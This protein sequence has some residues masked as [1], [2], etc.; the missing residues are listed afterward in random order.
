MRTLAYTVIVWTVV[1][2]S[3]GFAEPRPQA[4]GGGTGCQPGWRP[5]E[6]LPTSVGG[7][8]DVAV[9]DDGGG[10]GP[11]LFVS[12][13]AWDGERWS[14]IGDIPGAIHA[15]ATFDGGGGPALYFGGEFAE[16]DGLPA[17]RIARWDGTSLGPV[18]TGMYAAVQAF[19]LFDDGAGAALYAGGSFTLAGGVAANRVAKFDGTSW[20]PLGSG[21]NNVVRALAVYDDGSGPALYAGGGFTSAGGAGAS[22]VAKWDGTGWAPLSVGVDKTILCLEVFDDGNGPALY[23]G[24]NLTQAG[25]LAASCV[26]RWNGAWSS[27]GAGVAGQVT[28]FAVFD[29]GSGPRLVATI[30]NARLELWDGSAWSPPPPVGV[31]GS[32]YAFQVFD[33]GAGPELYIGGSFTRAGEATS[34]GIARWDGTGWASLAGGIAAGIVKGFAIFDD[35]AGSALFA[36]GSFEEIGGV[37]ADGLAKWNGTSWSA[38]GGMPDGYVNAVQTFD[39]GS[40]SALF[41]GGAFYPSGGLLRGVVKLDG[42]SW[43]VPGLGM[44]SGV[45]ALTVFDD[46]TG[47]ALYAGDADFPSRVARWDGTSWSAVGSGST[48]ERVLCLVGF[49]DGSGPA[50]YAGGWFTTMGGTPASRVAR[51]DGVSWSPLGPGLSGMNDRVRAL[52]VFDDGTGPA[53]YAAGDFTQAGAVSSPGIARWDGVGWASVG[54]SLASIPGASGSPSGF[55]LG[56]FDE[57]GDAGPALFIGGGFFVEETGDANL[58]RWQGCVD[59]SPPVLDC[60]ESVLARDGFTGPPGRPVHFTV[61]ASDASDPAPDVACVPPSGSTFPLGTTIVTCTATDEA[62]NEATCTFPVVVEPAVQRRR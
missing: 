46:G 49:D 18:G 41:V 14:S 50:L 44:H 25:G 55:G 21:T 47:S 43:S 60:P 51:W 5:L 53:L 36:A 28:A 3:A 24:G 11:R 19:A 59:T 26:A 58:A 27:P 54:D 52:A 16:V 1:A 15:M 42:E 9:F 56:V 8:S 38:I 34:R 31:E 39:D 45:E 7:G 4:R 12:D 20:S 29:P 62:G 57:P 32:V 48:N 17:S 37:A 61:T 23:A 6:G 33:A 30:G 10:A 35:G 22:R 2:V 13:V 40:G